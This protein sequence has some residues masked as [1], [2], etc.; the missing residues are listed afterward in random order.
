[1]SKKE[2]ECC[3]QTFKTEKELEA[4]MAR[5]HRSSCGGCGEKE[6]EAHMA[7][8]HRSSCGGCGGCCY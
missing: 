2:Y 7:R 8:Y 1:M 3:G 4:H 6:L 5:Y